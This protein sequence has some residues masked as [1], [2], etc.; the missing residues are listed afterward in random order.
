M[1]NEEFKREILD[2][3]SKSDLSPER[4]VSEERRNELLTLF[5]RNF[6]SKKALEEVFSVVQHSKV[7]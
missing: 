1:T 5:H 4:S 3:L 2:I 7:Q 6:F